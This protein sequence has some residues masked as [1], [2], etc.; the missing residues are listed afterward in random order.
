[1]QLRIVDKKA[2]RCTIYR[3]GKYSKAIDF[4]KNIK[5]DSSSG[6]FIEPNKTFEDGLLELEPGLELELELLDR[7]RGKNR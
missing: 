7:H 4:S 6:R 3:I 1:M 2:R 5:K